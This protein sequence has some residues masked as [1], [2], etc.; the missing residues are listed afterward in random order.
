M[1]P[2]GDAEVG[3]GAGGE[4]YQPR[5]ILKKEVGEAA[6]SCI[7]VPRAWILWVAVFLIGPHD[8][9]I[10]R[11]PSPQQCGSR[12]HGTK[13]SANTEKTSSQR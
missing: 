11:W 12:T 3:A 9:G 5:E 2:A 7:V 1:G 4:P 10:E 8:V 6:S 13:L